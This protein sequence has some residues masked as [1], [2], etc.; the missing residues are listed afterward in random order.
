[1]GLQEEIDSAQRQVRTD[2]YSMSIGEIVTMYQSEE[3][4]I[5][6]PFQRLFRWSIGQQSKFIESILLGIPI[7]PIFVFE[8]EDGTWELIDGLQRTSTILKFMG[9]LRKADSQ[10]LE[11][12]SYLE[13]THYLRSLKNAVWEKSRLIQDI[14]ESDQLEIS[15]P[16][17]LA[18]RRAKLNVQI[19][20]RPS[21]PETKYDLFQRLNRGGTV[22]NAQEVRNC[23]VIMISQQFF[24]LIHDELAQSDDFKAIAH[25]S[26]TGELRQRNIEMAMRFLVFISYEYTNDLDVEE[27]LDTYIVK[28]AEG[29]RPAEELRER[30]LGTFALLRQAL[31]DHALQKWNEE[32]QS[33][34][35]RVGQVALEVVAAGVGFN[36]QDILK[37]PQPA[38][39][40]EERIKDFWRSEQGAAFMAAGVRGT[41]RLASTITLG[42]QWFSR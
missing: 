29:D 18:I 2:G 34:G 31:G 12:P 22:A 16:Q 5:R 36:L 25:V 15:R 8:N 6:P 32:S 27:F 1:L 17:Q 37:R 3:I 33:F 4:I 41:Q 10:E 30:F 14:P 35:G 38:A 23:V 24:D 26:D 13:G 42:R 7:P 21:D 20:K 40:L 28:L 39:Y 11:A 9:L 19:L